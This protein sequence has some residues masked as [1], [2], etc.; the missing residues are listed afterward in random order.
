[1]KGGYIL[2]DCKQLDLLADETQTIDGL[3]DRVK[4]AMEQDK[5]VV[6]CNLMWGERSVTPVPVF[7]IDFGSAIICTASTLQ[8]IVD[9]DDHVTIN[10]MAPSV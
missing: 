9:P 10:N 3:H 5:P 4:A 8:V 2:V 1:M 7:C 6:A